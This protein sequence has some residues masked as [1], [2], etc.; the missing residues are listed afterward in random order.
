MHWC[1]RPGECTQNAGHIVLI[2]S[3]S[4]SGCVILLL[5]ALLGQRH[6]AHSKNR[7]QQIALA[8]AIFDI[9]GRVLVTS[10]GF[11]PNRKMTN[12]YLEKVNTAILIL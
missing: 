3:K 12:T 8:A 2:P 10:E 4:I 7:A 5:I 11:L 1:Y 9:D 6:I